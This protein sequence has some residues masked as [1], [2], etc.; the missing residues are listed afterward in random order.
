[1]QS[2]S[3]ARIVNTL[4]TELDGLEP[5]KQ[6]FVIG[7]TN[8]PDILDPAMCRPGR[9]DKL[10]Y[11]DLPSPAE[12]V[13]I[14]GACARKT[15]LAHD[16]DLVQVAHHPRAEG[17]SGADLAALV[18]EAATSAVKELFA[19]LDLDL[20]GPALGSSTGGGPL[21]AGATQEQLEARVEMRH[22]AAAL[23][24][25][26]P[27]VSRQQRR[28]FETLRR[29]FAGQP[30]GHRGEEGEAAGAGAAEGL[31]GG[32]ATAPAP[33]PDVAEL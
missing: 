10:L 28:R 7:A 29:R 6:V 20:D 17:L 13:E 32:E 23:E 31:E 16:V 15:P 24:R 18:R 2:E 1:M 30:V 19:A 5:R 11:V 14:L 8:R 25:A 33:R 4:L 21:G 3:S 27:S 12:R 22:F 9:L 26:N